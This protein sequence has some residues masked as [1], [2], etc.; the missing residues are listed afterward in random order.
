MPDKRSVAGIAIKDGTVFI[1]KRLPGGDLGGK[2]E[3]PGGKL[4]SG[5]NDE[6]AL[7][8]EY[9]EE[10]NIAITVGDSIAETHF[11]H[12][13]ANYQLAAHRIEL[14]ENG[15]SLIEHS[16]VQWV[17]AESLIRADLADSDRMLLPFILPMLV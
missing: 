17:S 6:Q 10:F 3:F 13:G 9:R 14:P 16:A 15:L 1:A 12:K 2:W 4:E 11:T 7:M 8:R 5:E